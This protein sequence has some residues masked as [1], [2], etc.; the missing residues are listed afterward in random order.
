LLYLFVLFDVMV[1]YIVR[2]SIVVYFLFPFVCAAQEE[3]SWAGFGIEANAFTGKVIK[4]TIKFELPVPAMSDGMDLNF[5]LKTNGHKEWQQRRNYP[6]VG[7]GISYTNY[8][9]D[10]IYGRCLGIYPNITIPII[11]GKRLEWTV[12]I[13]DG[14]GYVNRAYSRTPYLDTINNAIGSR[15]NDYFSFLSDVRF[16]INRHWDVQAGINFS[17]ISDASFHQ[18]NLGINLAGEHFGVRYFPVT[19]RPK[20]IKRELKPLKDR[21]LFQLRA[22]MGFNESN[23]PLGPLYPIYVGTAFV[24]K[25]WISKNKFFAGF[26]YSYSEQIYSYLRNNIGLGVPGSTYWNAYKTAVFAGNEFLLGRVGAVLQLGYYVHQK[27]DIQEKFYEKIGGNLYL[28]RKEHG[29]I[30]EFYIC[31]FLNAHLAVAEFSEAG[32]GIGL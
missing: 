27:F 21:W 15:V 19:S 31:A 23:A 16:Q 12:R 2:L 1:R 11:S 30:K 25:R 14:I 18:P 24:S 32:F 4:H 8:G 29:P 20:Q 9:N 7:V 10:S 28:V 26:D 6:I 3:N 17:H 5:V 13:G 22:T